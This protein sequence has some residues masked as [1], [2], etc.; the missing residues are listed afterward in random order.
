[1]ENKLD[2]KCRQIKTE[3]QYSEYE[4]LAVSTSSVS[5]QYTGLRVTE[6]EMLRN[7]ACMGGQNSTCMSFSHVYT[8]QTIAG[9][10]FS[11]PGVR[12]SIEIHQSVSYHKLAQY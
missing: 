3:T 11:F 5:N 8:V 9:F 12:S 2:S 10:L 6:Y 4:M 7:L 1:M